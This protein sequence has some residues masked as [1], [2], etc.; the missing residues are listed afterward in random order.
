VKT[1][2][3]LIRDVMA[4]LAW[5]PAVR[6]TDVGV[7]V[8]DGIVTLTGHVDTLAEKHAAAQAAQRVD[9]VH[10]VAVAF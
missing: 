4:E 7:T 2:A 1:D 3:H 8:R 5:D 6:S 10:A 9:G